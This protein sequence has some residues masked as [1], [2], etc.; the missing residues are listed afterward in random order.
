MHGRSHPQTVSVFGP[1]MVLDD[2]IPDTIF[3]HP[4]LDFASTHF[5]EEGT[6]DHPRNT[7]DAA[8]STARLMREALAEV[9]DNRPFLDSEH[10]PIHTYKDHHR[11]LP[12]PFDDEYFRHIQWAHLCAGG[13]GGGMRWPN[14]SPHTLTK[15]MREAQRGLASFL[16]LMDWKSFSRRNWNEE[17]K[18]SNSAIKAVAC[19]D[20]RQAL[21]WLVRKDT[22][23][24]SRLLRRDATPVACVVELP[25]LRP[26]RYRITAWNTLLGR[27]SD[28]F[29]VE[30]SS[31]GLRF[32]VP[33]V[34]TDLA[35]AIRS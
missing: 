26:G 13:A 7:V 35:L 15:G 2:R 32:E 18:V 5:Y 23:G 1:H 29:T 30:S 25:C 10:G 28:D 21:V 19:G 4:S 9:R 34:T 22:I 3:R 16:P 8:I 20:L 24:K 31:V 27:V 12:E 33:S 11:T 17:I 6:I 14:R